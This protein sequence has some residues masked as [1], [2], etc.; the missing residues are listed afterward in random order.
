MANPSN[1]Y[2]EKVFAEHPIALWSLDDDAGFASFISDTNK[3]VSTWTKTGAGATVAS[4]DS[5]DSPLR[6]DYTTEVSISGAAST[7]T[8]TSTATFTSTEAETFSVGFYFYDNSQKITKIEV[9]YGANLFEVDLP[10]EGSFVTDRQWIL[11]SKQIT[12][13][14]VSASNIVI[15]V[16]YDAPTGTQTFLINGVSVGN[17]SE[18]FNGITT[19]QYPS[20][21]PA[22]VAKA[23]YAWTGTTNLSTST[24]TFPNGVVRTNFLK[25]PNF[26]SNT[27]GWGVRNGAVATSTADEYIGTRSAL[28]T[29]STS[30]TTAGINSSTGTYLVPVTPGK[31][32][33]YSIYLKDINTSKQYVNSIDYYDSGSTFISGSGVSGTAVTIST[34]KWTR[35]SYTFT[36]PETVGTSPTTPAYVRPYTY[37]STSFVSGDSGKQLYF[38]AAMVE[39]SDSALEYFDGSLGQ[40]Y[41]TISADSYGYANYDGYYVVKNNKLTASNSGMPMVYGASSATSCFYTDS[42]DPSL[43]LPAAGFLH[44]NGSG[45]NLSLEAWLRIST[46]ATEE[47]RIL[48]PIGSTDG[49]Y[50]KGPFLM[51]RVDSHYG[52]HYVGEWNRPMLININSFDNGASLIV[53]GE[54]AISLSFDRDAIQFETSATKNFIGFYAHSDVTRIDVDCVAIYPYVVPQEVAKRRYIYGQGVEFPEG[55]NAAYNGE[56]F[57]YDYSFA[58][59]SNNSSYPSTFS[60]NEALVENL[61]V[62]RKTLT[63]PKY[64]KPTLYFE[65]SSESTEAT[66]LAELYMANIAATTRPKNFFSF[67]GQGHFLFETLNKLSSKA[68]SL[69]GTFRRTESTTTEQVLIKIIDEASGDYLKAAL[70][71][72]QV[73]YTFYSNGATVWTL[74]MAPTISVGE[75]FICGFSFAQMILNNNV[76]GLARFLSNSNNLKVFVGGGDT[77]VNSGKISYEHTFDG[78]IYSVGFSNQRNYN[79]IE[80]YFDA[81]SGVIENVDT[82]AVVTEL[83]DHYA[84]YTL[85]FKIIAEQLIIDIAIDGYWQDYIPLSTLSKYITNESAEREYEID[86]VQFNIDYPK[87]IDPSSEM[88]RSYLSFQT[89]ASGANLVPATKV[90]VSSNNAVVADSVD[91]ATEMYEVVSGDV[92]YP[93]SGV[94]TQTLALDIHLEFQVDGIFS[95]PLFIR[96]M[97]ISSKALNAAENPIDSKFGTSVYPYVV[98]GAGFDYRAQNPITLGKRKSP[99]L[100]LSEDSGIKL[101]GADLDGTRGLYFKINKTN[102]SYYKISSMSMVFKYPGQAFPSTET[103]I[104]SIQDKFKTISFYV[105]ATNTSGTRGKVYM[106]QG[107]SAFY[108]ATMFLNGKPTSQ[109]EINIG[110]WNTLGVSF[111]SILDFENDANLKIKVV[112]KILINSLSFFQVSDEESGQVVSVSLWN[113][114]SS[115]PWS[116]YNATYDNWLDVLVTEVPP[117]IYGISPKDIFEIYSGTH[118]IIPESENVV[119]LEFSAH[120]YRA[121]INYTPLTYTITPA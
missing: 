112:D 86:Y 26:E 45:N 70:L 2:A 15:K 60:W 118:K 63:L 31:T 35:I 7:V 106:K 108:D 73:V 98:D 44:A 80:S 39:E 41:T 28:F 68:S 107:A 99:Y 21:F 55:L 66:L 16:T 89:I 20:T 32:Y 29:V 51:L 77:V 27:T 34:T 43:I 114:I 14:V 42:G 47:K 61:V 67:Q 102:A 38:D 90:A 72:S 65:G 120:S 5:T 104:F 58:N 95:N 24:K 87:S 62:D 49:L 54:N 12:E 3:D 11:V 52:L 119:Q 111:S 69:Y 46:T 8:I 76:E 37:S 25:N 6:D 22:T 101:T 117:K 116:T 19:A 50:V 92:I 110:Q 94:D 81:D 82:G 121:Y 109:T 1:L 64:T 59:Y 85:I 48:G 9:G 83:L 36:V 74:T 79:K 96:E 105:I 91:W 56:S 113:D 30:G 18:E 93:P 88:I 40:T 71:S 53:N 4:Y 57:L 78:H 115:S 84:S 75:D 13:R 100:Y 10:K 23:T 17:H 97:Q 103:E 33:T